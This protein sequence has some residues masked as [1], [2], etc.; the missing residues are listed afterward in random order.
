MASMSYDEI[1][2]VAMNLSE[3]DR[4]RMAAELL[5][6]LESRAL[7]EDDPGFADELRRRAAELDADPSL[8]IDGDEF[9][10]EMRARYG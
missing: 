1:I 10:R 4:C 7:S 3:D 9:L 6:S 8:A 5:D 2:R